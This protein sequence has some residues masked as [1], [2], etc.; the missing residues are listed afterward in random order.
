MR[1]EYN[2][3]KSAANPYSK[4]LKQQVTIRLEKETIEYFKQLADEIDIPY[5]KLINLY[6]RNC[7]EKELK[8]SLSWQE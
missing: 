6:L 4:R 3:S 8:P 7:A 1:K 2:F 5:Q